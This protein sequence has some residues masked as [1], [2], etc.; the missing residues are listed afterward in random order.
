MSQILPLNSLLPP[1]RND[2]HSITAPRNLIDAVLHV[3]AS[4]HRSDLTAYG[5]A[6]LDHAYY[7]Y[8]QQFIQSAR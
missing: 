4:K 5:V 7:I 8:E 1:R 2:S 6:Q 3:G